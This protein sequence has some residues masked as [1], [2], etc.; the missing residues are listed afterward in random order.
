V[1]KG[2]LILLTVLLLLPGVRGGR[3]Q[4]V[5]AIAITDSTNYLIGD[6]IHVRVTLTHPAGVTFQPVVPDTVGSFQVIERQPFRQDG[7]TRTVTEFVVARY[8]SGDAVLAPLVFQY[9]LPG[10]SASRSVA[11][12]PLRLKIHT[13]AVDTTKEI[14][15]LKPPMSI[16]LSAAEIMEI[17][18]I[19][20]LVA[21]LA[22]A[23]WRYWKKR[24]ARAEGEVSVLPPRAAHVIALEE[25]GRLKE[26][27]LWQQ[28]L[29]KQFYVEA[30]EIF[31][32]YIENRYRQEAL[33]QTS[34][35]IL[36]GLRRL[37]MPEELV[38]R[39]EDA[40]RRADL[41]KFAKQVPGIPEHEE[42]LK[43]VQDFVQRTRIIET[44]SGV[45][46]EGG[47]SPHVGS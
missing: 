6:A 9:S 32:R 4:G 41:V 47:A 42:T 2:S 21:A 38:K 12:N 36:A 26:K 31:R 3:A 5:S 34:D 14:R 43:F 25:L 17:L 22:Y 39:A 27:R 16:P 35:E 11:T 8:D 30:T 28:G 13:V 1:R 18:G 37:G 15:D 33:E 29:I 20:L 40:L 46:A 7:E 24:K 23:G 44:E 10:D 45:T 19:L